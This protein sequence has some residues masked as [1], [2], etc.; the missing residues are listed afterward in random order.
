MLFTA[1]YT[2]S[3]GAV[4]QLTKQV[5]LDYAPDR[6]HCNAIAPGF[7]RT[8]MTQNLQNDPDKFDEI[9]KAHPFGGMGSTEDVAKAALFLVSDDVAWI[10]GVNLPVD[11]GYMIM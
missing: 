8:I 11:G 10:T 5:A 4:A 6:I 3:K 1:A 9:N 2:A 7:L